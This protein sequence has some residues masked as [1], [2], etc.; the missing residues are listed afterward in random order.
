MGREG[1]RGGKRARSASKETGMN[2]HSNSIGYGANF[3]SIAR[4]S[5]AASKIHII[6][7]CGQF[8]IASAVQAAQ[9]ERSALEAYAQVEALAS[10][11]ACERALQYGFLATPAEGMA[12]A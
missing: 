3:V 5:A 2:I 7:R 1:K 4:F 9:H 10:E 8:H 12:V 6:L 11:K